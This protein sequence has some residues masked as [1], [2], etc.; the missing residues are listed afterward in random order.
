[1]LAVSLGLSG[2]A[3]VRYSARVQAATENEVRR[4]R[5]SLQRLLDSAAEGLYGV[6][7]EGR[8]TFINRSAL[9]MLGYE[10]ESELLG[11][12]MQTLIHR[13][14]ERG[15]GGRFRRIARSYRE[16]RELHVA[17]E[18][19]WRRDGSSFPVEYWSH[20][21]QGDGVLQGSVATFFDITERLHMQA[22]LRQGEVRMTGLVDAVND[23]VITIDADGKV[24]LFNRA[25]E[26][27]FGVPATRSHRQPGR[28]LHPAPSAQRRT[29]PGR[30]PLQLGDARSGE[31]R[32]LFGR[33]ADEQEFPL[34]VSLSRHETERGPLLTAVLRDVTGL[35]TARAERQAR[36]ALEASSRAK[37]EF[38]SRM[39]HEL[40]TPL[41]AV[42]GFSQLLRLDAPSRRRC[43]SSPASSTSRTPAATSWR[44]ST[45]CSTC[46]GWSRAR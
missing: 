26:R 9:A 25:A 11:R 27:L 4:R 44:W 12:E 18:L 32:E 1:M 3:F 2:L 34:E 30:Q 45:T 13:P 22:A 6:D 10:R 39:S 5:E 14:P 42:L 37:T 19:L 38:L 43:S 46:R 15:A 8:C 40:R 16:S 35:Q 23:G 28:P 24:V 17:G 36:E 7:T 21:M 20:P 31:V 41:N 29:P 33:R